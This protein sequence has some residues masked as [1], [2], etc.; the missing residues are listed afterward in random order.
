M[1]RLNDVTE[2]RVTQPCWRN[3]SLSLSLSLSV[4]FNGHFP[5]EPGKPVFTEAKDDESGGINWS[6]NSCKAPVK[7][8]PSDKPTPVNLFSSI[9]VHQQLRANKQHDLT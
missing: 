9:C 1:T 4:R 6:Y 8:S 2:T 3:L 5:G 7:S